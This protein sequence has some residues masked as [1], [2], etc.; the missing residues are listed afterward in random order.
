MLERSN[1]NRLTGN[2]PENFLGPFGVFG[3]RYDAHLG[4]KTHPA[5]WSNITVGIFG[6][7]W[8]PNDP[9][10]DPRSPQMDLKILWEISSRIGPSR[11]L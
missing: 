5:S 9:Y 8:C 7:D 11:T 10:I 2:F 1:C 3:D 6:L 4:K